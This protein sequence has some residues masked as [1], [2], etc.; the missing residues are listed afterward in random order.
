MESLEG[1]TLAVQLTHQLL[2]IERI[3]A[4]LPDV[5]DGMTFA[6][7]TADSEEAEALL[8]RPGW[9][10]GLLEVSSLCSRSWLGLMWGSGPQSC[11]TSCTRLYVQSLTQGPSTWA[12]E[13]IQF[14]SWGSRCLRLLT[15]SSSGFEDFSTRGLLTGWWWHCE[16]VFF[17]SGSSSGATAKRPD[18]TTGDVGPPNSRRGCAGLLQFRSWRSSSRRSCLCAEQPTCHCK[19]EAPSAK[20]GRCVWTHKSSGC[21]AEREQRAKETVSCP[22]CSVVLALPLCL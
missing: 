2:E 3:P 8:V 21:V 7:R 15:H 13:R 20:V 17:W 19:D 5:W 16:P 9:S 11:S 12:T 1:T 6:F 22:G 18:S 14:R 4:S 10:L